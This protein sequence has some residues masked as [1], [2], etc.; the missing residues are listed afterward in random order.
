[1]KVPRSFRR[2]RLPPPARLLAFAV[3][4]L[5]AVGAYA[6]FAGAPLSWDGASLLFAV[7][8]TESPYLPHHRYSVALLQLPTLLFQRHTENVALLSFVFSLTFAAVP[9]LSAFVSYRLV[10]DDHPR[11][12]VWPILWLS[13]GAVFGQ[14]FFVTES[15]ILLA[16]A[17]PLLLVV[18]TRFSP[19]RVL[20]CAAIAAFA[21]D[22]HPASGPLLLL[23]GASAAALAFQGGPRRR[24]LVVAALLLAAFGFARIWVSL[25]DGYELSQARVDFREIW[26]S[27]RLPPAA[28]VASF[29]VVVCLVVASVVRPPRG[30]PL[31]GVMAAMLLVIAITMV[32]YANTPRLWQDGL[33]FRFLAPFAA[34]PF[35]LGASIA[36]VTT[37]PLNDRLSRKEALLALGAALVC[38]LVL[39]TQCRKWVALRRSL[40]TAVLH[41]SRC[42]SMNA[43]PA[44]RTT[45]L[46]WWPTPSYAL[47][48]Q[49]HAPR[50]LLLPGTD[51]QKRKLDEVVFVN[52]WY[53]RSRN[54]GWF[55]LREAGRGR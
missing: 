37:T 1:M 23:V 36:A 5:A 8:D 46:K 27:L 49:G 44:C 54:V 22:L 16:G 29:A 26:R 50:A 11:L 17:W 30:E 21:F 39:G 31:F 51:C 14:L 10:R 43:L 20:L 9:A 53:P 15:L 19:P 34:A 28:V 2:A 25:H 52:P 38:T 41:S 55:D 47:L 42:L 7:L 32:R 24:S 33:N 4:L 40:E 18:L 3:A 13:L 6:A 48:V 45:A 12:A 35:F